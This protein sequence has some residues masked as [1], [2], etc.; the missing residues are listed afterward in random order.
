M[1]DEA[2]EIFRTKHSQITKKKKKKK[3]KKMSCMQMRVCVI[4]KLCSTLRLLKLR[5]NRHFSLLNNTY[6]NL[7]RRFVTEARNMSVITNM[8]V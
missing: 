5:G 4:G 2:F 3:R 1:K 8:Y 6:Y 7:P